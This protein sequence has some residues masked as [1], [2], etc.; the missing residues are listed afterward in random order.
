MAPQLHNP[1]RSSK[2]EEAQRSNG[3][4]EERKFSGKAWHPLSDDDDTIAK[5][6]KAKL[7]KANEAK[8]SKATQRAANAKQSTVL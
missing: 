1:A 3:C 6:S 4:T 7:S 2:S 5:V 8:Q